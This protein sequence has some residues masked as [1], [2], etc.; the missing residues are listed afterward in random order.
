MK[1][2]KIL[3]ITPNFFPNIGGSETYFLNII[4]YFK[5]TQFIVYTLSYSDEPKSSLK[6]P[7]LVVKRNHWG[8]NRLKNIIYRT[9]SPF[10]ISSYYFLGLFTL[11]I[12]NFIKDKDGIGTIHTNGTAGLF[13]GVLLNK[14]FRMR[15]HVITTIL[16][17]NHLL[18]KNR[19]I[20]LTLSWV[21]NNTDLVFYHTSAIK[22]NLLHSF[23]DIKNKLIKTTNI[24]DQNIFRVS[25]YKNLYGFKEKKE[26]LDLKRS[27][28]KICLF[29][30]RFVWYKQIDFILQ[31]IENYSKIIQKPYQKTCFLFCGS[32]PLEQNIIRLKMRLKND[33]LRILIKHPLPQQL[34]FYYNAADSLFW[35]SIGYREV[36]MVCIEGMACGLPVF[37]SIY[38]FEVWS[39]LAF[40]KNPKN[41]L[42]SNSL[43]VEEKDPEKIAEKLYYFIRRKFD[44]QIANIFAR[45]HYSL[46]KLDVYKKIYEAS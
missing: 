37:T 31:I 9:Q 19:I 46:K 4:K 21:L 3:I 22:N 25:N 38:S 41:I 24:Y 23:P 12:R 26:I 8:S 33:K 36:S 13:L 29:V 35:P 42:S 1:K 15:I 5:N 14:I 28:Y 39:N 7:N 2:N 32:G 16:G 44:R 30:G 40:R 20:K 45:N 43:M 11:S 27:G 6:L 34:S 17:A 10:L 18:E